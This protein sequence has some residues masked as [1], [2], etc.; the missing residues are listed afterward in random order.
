MWTRARLLA[1]GVSSGALTVAAP[2][3]GALFPPQSLAHHLTT[4]LGS[5]A[6]VGAFGATGAGLWAPRTRAA[7][8]LRSRDAA[9]GQ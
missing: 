4:G 3:V 1:V 9:D 6:L 8:A 7:P 5:L 2:A